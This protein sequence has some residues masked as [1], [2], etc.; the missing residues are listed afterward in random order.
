MYQE[1][2]EE[3]LRIIWRE[4]PFVIAK[5]TQDW[6]EHLLGKKQF[7]E[8]YIQWSSKGKKRKFLQTEG[9]FKTRTCPHMGYGRW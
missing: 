5:R 8:K 6:I 3:Q 1:I 4:L 7:S 2:T 9:V